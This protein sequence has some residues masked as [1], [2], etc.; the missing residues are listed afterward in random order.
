M[1]LFSLGN[2][3]SPFR[4]GYGIPS[5]DNIIRYRRLKWSGHVDGVGPDRLPNQ[6]LSSKRGKTAK[7]TVNEEIE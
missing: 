1:L 4:V 3:L 7:R 6:G 2:G 5:I